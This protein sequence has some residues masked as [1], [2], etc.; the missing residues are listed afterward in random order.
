MVADRR[1]DCLQFR[2]LGRIPPSRACT[3]STGRHRHASCNEPPTGTGARHHYV[4]PRFSPDGRSLVYT[5]IRAGK[6][7]PHGY[8]GEVTALYV[9]GVDGSDPHRITPWGIT[10]GDADWS[11]DG[12]H[13]VFETL[14]EHLGNG[15]S[16]MAVDPDGAQP[17][18]PA[19]TTPASPVSADGRACNS[20]PASTRAV[21]GRHQ[22]HVQRRPQV[23]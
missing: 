13:I 11:P 8:R 21:A 3:W 17:A 18:R 23:H 16:V 9:V 1:L 19:P 4:S 22:D 20:R 12:Q 14:T 15:A 10:P 6:E 2:Q 7:L 5:S